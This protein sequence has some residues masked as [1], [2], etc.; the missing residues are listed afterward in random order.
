MII[1]QWLLQFR[2]NYGDY[3]YR[4]VVVVAENAEQA[5]QL[6]HRIAKLTHPSISGIG[7]PQELLL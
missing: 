1:R 2:E 7:F 3:G 4:T 5:E 6:Q